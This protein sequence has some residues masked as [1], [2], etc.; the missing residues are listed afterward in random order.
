VT[1]QLGS[2]PHLFSRPQTVSAGGRHVTFAPSDTAS[3]T[4]PLRPQDG[5]CRVVFSVTPTAVP[6]LTQRGNGDLRVLGAHF[7][8]FLYTAP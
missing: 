5:V 1:V 6:A 4:V 3:L 7:L 8:R 2:D